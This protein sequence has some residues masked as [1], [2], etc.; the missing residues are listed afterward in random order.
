M[1]PDCAYNGLPLRR[2]G[3]FFRKMV[4]TNG[5]ASPRLSDEGIIF[6]GIIPF[7]LDESILDKALE[8]YNL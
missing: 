4:I 7:L 3:D 1:K 2:C 6:V 5:Y 8:N